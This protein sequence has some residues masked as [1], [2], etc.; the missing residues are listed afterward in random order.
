[1]AP[2]AKVIP[3]PEK[4]VVAIPE[5]D[6]KAGI[7]LKAAVYIAPRVL[8]RSAILDLRQSDSAAKHII[9]NGPTGAATIAAVVHY[10]PAAFDEVYLVAHFPDARLYKRELD[11]VIVIQD[12][13]TRHQP[14][15]TELANDTWETQINLALYR[16]DGTRITHYTVTASSM[17]AAGTKPSDPEGIIRWTYR[18]SQDAIKPAVRLALQRFPKTEVLNALQK[19]PLKTSS[20]KT[21]KYWETTHMEFEQRLDKEKIFLPL[22]DMTLEQ[23]L[24]RPNVHAVENMVMGNAIV[25]LNS[26]LMAQYYAQSPAAFQQTI[27]NPGTLSPTITRVYE[28]QLQTL[29]EGQDPNQRPLA[30]Q[31]IG[32]ANKPVRMATPTKPKSPKPAITKKQPFAVAPLAP[33]NESPAIRKSFV[34]LDGLKHVG[35][36]AAGRAPAE[37]SEGNCLDDLRRIKQ[38]LLDSA[39]E[40]GASVQLLRSATSGAVVYSN[41]TC[42]TAIPNTINKEQS[43]NEAQRIALCGV[44]TVNCA[45]AKIYAGMD[46]QL[47]VNRCR[48]EAEIPK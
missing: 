20:A 42:S 19:Q 18:A 46:C 44:Q 25:L 32:G 36:P 28:Q 6:T 13:A 26:K 8:G 11:L 3:P 15:N 12:T 30:Y 35:K 7:P 17:P 9:N 21:Q 23:Y 38:A 16:L 48:Q 27:L 41:K 43:A 37:G 2:P 4:E 47:A 24:N 40:S 1:M 5:L 10:F 33:S 22:P 31:F 29:A 39:K 14:D 34:L 45:M